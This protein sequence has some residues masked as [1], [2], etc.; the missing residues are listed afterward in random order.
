MA[1]GYK[2]L[3]KQGGISKLQ[4][5]QA[6]DDL[7]ALQNQYNGVVER[8][9]EIKINSQKQ[10]RQLES[11]IKNAEQQLRYQNITADRDG[12]V[13]DLKAQPGS[14][15]QSGEV[16]LSIVPFGSLKAK[17]YVPNKDIGFIEKGQEATVRVDAFPSSRYGEL[18]GQIEVIGADTLPPDATYNYYRFP[19]DIELTRS[20]LETNNYKIPLRVGMSV[21][22]NLKIR[23]K[24]MITLVSDFFGGQ[25]D[26]IKALR[27]G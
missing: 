25:L 20:W 3:S 1:Q 26:S 27:G 12:I 13:F 6:N 5:L 18:D 7:L 16:I 11:S 9:E 10:I 21:T 2:S 8:R 22:S 14:V 17:V 15:I 24:R 23:E 4:F 19:V